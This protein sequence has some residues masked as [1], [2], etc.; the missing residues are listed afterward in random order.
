[1]CTFKNIRLIRENAR[2][3][4]SDVTKTKNIDA[5]KEIYDSRNK[6][7]IYAHA[8]VKLAI[9]YCEIRRRHSFDGATKF[10]IAESYLARFSAFSFFF[11]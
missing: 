2:C 4:I 6:R 9:L 5:E 7:K 8:D 10:N 11:F 1:M 3:K